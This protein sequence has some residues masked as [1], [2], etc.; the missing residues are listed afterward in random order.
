MRE[1]QSECHATK[2]RSYTPSADNR[3][4]E[5]FCDQCSELLQRAYDLVQEVAAKVKPVG[6]ARKTRITRE[7]AHRLLDQA[8]DEVGA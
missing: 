6:A 1:C 8:Y 4:P 3:Y 2:N 5:H 7:Q